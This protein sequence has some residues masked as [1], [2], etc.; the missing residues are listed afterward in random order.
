MIV[1]KGRRIALL[2]VSDKRAKAI[3]RSMTKDQY[4][5]FPVEDDTDFL[6]IAYNEKYSLHEITLEEVADMDWLYIC[7]SPVGR[8]K[9]GT[10]TSETSSKEEEPFEF[11]SSPALVSDAPAAEQSRAMEAAIFESKDADPRTAEEVQDALNDRMWT[12]YRILKAR[13]YSPRMY[14]GL[15]KVTL[16]K[17]S[18]IK[19]SG[20]KRK[21]Q[22][23]TF[24]EKQMKMSI[25][26][27][28][29]T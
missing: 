15:V 2:R 23:G 1:A 9:S 29:G 10:L 8:N 19:I 28:I 4:E 24:M 3:T 27:G 26:S 17:V 7:N 6:F 12:A 14:Y 21:K 13:G 18:W 5:R 16:S 22:H 25:G 11:I 20:H